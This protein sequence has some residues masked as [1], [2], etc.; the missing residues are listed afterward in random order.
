MRNKNKYTL[1]PIDVL[2]DKLHKIILLIFK[3]QCCI[4]VK[5]YSYSLGE[6]KENDILTQYDH[7]EFMVINVFWTEKRA[8]KFE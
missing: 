3:D 8:H 4:K 5:L 6:Y 1:P 2:L 7:Y